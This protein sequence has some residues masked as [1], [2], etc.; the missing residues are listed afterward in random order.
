MEED[1]LEIRLRVMERQLKIMI[2]LVFVS[3]TCSLAAL[4]I[5]AFVLVTVD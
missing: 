5:T 1:K 3:L 4:I 2:A